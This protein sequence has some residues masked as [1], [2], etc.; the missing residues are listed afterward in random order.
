MLSELP[1]D[2]RNAVNVPEY[3]RT[4]REQGVGQF[5]SKFQP[6]QRKIRCPSMS[7]VLSWTKVVIMNGMRRRSRGL[8]A[9]LLVALASC[10]NMHLA[11]AG[12]VVF[13]D[14]F[15]CI[16]AYVDPG[17]NTE[18]CVLPLPVPKWVEWT[19]IFAVGPKIDGMVPRDAFGKASILVE[20]LNGDGIPV[21]V[22]MDPADDTRPDEDLNEGYVADLSTSSFP[23]VYGAKDGDV[24][25]NG[26]FE[27]SNTGVVRIAWKD[28]QFFGSSN[29]MNDLIADYENPDPGKGNRLFGYQVLRSDD[30]GA[31][32][33]DLT[34]SEYPFQKATNSGL[35]VARPYSWRKR[36][37]TAA[38]QTDDA[39][40]F[41]DYSVQSFE[42]NRA[43]ERARVYWYKV[44]PYLGGIPLTVPDDL[45]VIRVTLPPPNMA[46][47]HRMMANR[48]ICNEMDK[49][50][51]TAPGRHY[52]CAYDGVGS[53]GLGTPWLIT[54]TVYDLGGDLLVDRFEMGCNMTRGS[55]LPLSNST[56]S[57]AL[58]DFVGLDD[59]AQPFQGCVA[60]T[61]TFA[62]E[63][64]PGHGTIPP[65]PDI[66]NNWDRV[67]PGDCF[68][69][70]SISLST[71]GL[72]ASPEECADPNRVLRWNFLWPGVNGGSI[73]D[74]NLPGNSYFGDLDGDDSWG[75][76]DG[77]DFY[78]ELMQSEVA[79]VYYHRENAGY[80][81]QLRYPGPGN[82]DISLGTNSARQPS[83]CFVNLPGIESDHDPSKW[84]PRWFPLNRLFDNEIQQNGSGVTLYDKTINEILAD[85]Q[86]YDQGSPNKLRAPAFPA[87]SRYDAEQTPLGKIIAS[88]DSK[89]PPLTYLSQIDMNDL[90]ALHDVEVGITDPQGSSFVNLL[91]APLN[92]RIARKTE[93]IVMSAWP[94]TWEEAKV[95]EMEKGAGVQGHFT[96]NNEWLY[97][98]AGEIP[99]NNNATCNVS[100]KVNGTGQFLAQSDSLITTA[101]PHKSDSNAWLLT[102]SSSLDVNGNANNT[103]R[104]VSRFGIQDFV[105]NTAEYTTDELF[106]DY[107]GE[108]MW[109]GVM[110]AQSL[111]INASANN[112]EHVS[113]DSSDV[114]AWV[115]SAANTGQCSTVEPGGARGGDYTSG[116]IINS[117]YDEAGGLNL[118]ILES[119]KSLDQDGVLST[120]NGDGYFLD[121]GPDNLG[122]PLAYGDVMGIG[123][124]RGLAQNGASNRAFY[125]NPATG[126]PLECPGT[127]CIQSPDNLAIT[128][129]PQI[130]ESGDFPFNYAIADFPTN[131][132][133]IY[134]EGLRD[135]FVTATNLSPNVLGL[136]FYYVD[137]VASGGTNSEADD[138]INQLPKCTNPGDAADG[139]CWS[140]GSVKSE[141]AGPDGEG[142]ADG[143]FDMVTTRRWSWQMPRGYPLQ[144]I[145]GGQAADDYA[146][147]YHFNLQSRTQPSL[148]RTYGHGGR[149]VVMIN[150]E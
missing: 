121:Y 87:S 33:L 106:C 108:T 95:D 110:G 42:D 2:H 135:L 45:N 35:L 11:H 31:S 49:P 144:F 140:N 29:S 103:E 57:G 48:L 17:D 75:D 23:G 5:P 66:A 100:A 119:L 101:F 129:T 133:Q 127:T 20:T 81:T 115:L 25:N 64:E 117:I 24:A 143:L 145:V 90:C 3:W 120:R 37:N 92:K 21:E 138:V 36:N 44:V 13:N 53:K 107:S 59:L 79:A 126:L 61:N 122:P 67:R 15:E 128:T 149:C 52:S 137:S 1:L 55:N 114:D 80:F 6:I 40:V 51:D 50:I 125:F 41:T 30:N 43:V 99:T 19:E 85:P 69:F 27:F 7:R 91:Q 84:V 10:W 104:C 34:S 148:R 16:R 78:D 123:P 141:F 82:N 111:S 146:G 22:K 139:V 83:L 62:D 74:C 97:R 32:W 93:T 4:F 86:M 102:G 12:E 116:L 76:P 60:N 113:I 142:F 56:Y 47:V 105:G 28:I 134:N 94:Q 131:N 118:A 112:V 71:Y 70:G 9:F 18:S 98:V 147:R 38:N 89:L 46:L 124:G 150:E 63:Y 109:F 54:E 8:S 58:K 130:M 132:S 73:Y 65:N 136:P 72:G 88:N 77:Y 96:D 14:G 26:L 68:G 39:V